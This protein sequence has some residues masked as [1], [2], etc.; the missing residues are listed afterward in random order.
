MNDVKFLE[1]FDGPVDGDD[2]RKQFVG[3]MFECP[4]CGSWHSLR[5]VPGGGYP[6]WEFDGD[7][8]K[9]TFKPSIISRWDK[10]V[11][12]QDSGHFEEQ[13][14]HFFLRKGVFEFL[15]D[16]THS[17]AGEKLPMIPID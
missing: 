12:P 16:C 4:G 8:E 13:V 9:P 14:C 2:P 17:K 10:W 7:M 6:C 1:P 3:Y 11:G 5:T 15:S